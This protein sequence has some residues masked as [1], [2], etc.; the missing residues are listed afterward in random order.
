ML[1][2]LCIGTEVNVPYLISVLQLSVNFL[3]YLLN[4]LCEYCLMDAVNNQEVKNYMQRR[5]SCD[6]K[7][8]REC[9]KIPCSCCMD[10]SSPC[11]LYKVIT[12][13]SVLCVRIL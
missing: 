6:Q 9:E 12:A 3:E 10:G 5:H 13:A 7:H 11:S 2:V 4:H 1:V 8:S